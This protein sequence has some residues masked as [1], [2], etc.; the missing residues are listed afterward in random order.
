MS[1]DAPLIRNI[2]GIGFD[3]VPELEVLDEAVEDPAEAM[4]GAVWSAVVG[5]VLHVGFGRLHPGAFVGDRFK[6]QL[7][8]YVCEDVDARRIIGEAESSGP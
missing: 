1:F 2:E 8:A 7:L 6:F 4:E 3:N 5:G